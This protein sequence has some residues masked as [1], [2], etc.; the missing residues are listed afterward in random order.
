MFLAVAVPSINCSSPPAA[1]SV[2]GPS[3]HTRTGGNGPPEHMSWVKRS[4]GWIGIVWSWSLV[5]VGVSNLAMLSQC[6]LNK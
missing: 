4:S 1:A 6:N 5:V 2:H 3:T